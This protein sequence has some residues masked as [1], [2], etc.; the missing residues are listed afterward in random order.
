MWQKIT[1]ISIVNLIFFT[2][3]WGCNSCGCNG[4]QK[5]A[6]VRE[7]TEIE[8]EI[9]E[10]KLVQKAFTNFMQ[11]GS[12]DLSPDPHQEKSSYKHQI[13]Q[14]APKEFGWKLP[15]G[16]SIGAE[17]PM[18]MFTAIVQS[19]GEC[20]LTIFP[21][22]VG[23]LQ[24][25]VTRWLQQLGV[26]IQLEKLEAMLEDFSVERSGHYP[27]LFVDLKPVTLNNKE[28]AYVGIFRYKDATL[29]VKFTGPHSSLDANRSKFLEFSKSIHPK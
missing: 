14:I 24:S 1:L 15:Q 8:G 17:K 26:T 19:G 13:P 22:D 25:N 21:G 3:S 16:W 29:F 9:H 20:V 11:M 10:R 27:F 7:Y 18:R 12:K 5:H 6:V 4:A 23:G 28:S 2:A